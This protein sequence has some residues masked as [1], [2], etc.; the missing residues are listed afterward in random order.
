MRLLS[1]AATA[2]AACACACAALAQDAT[3]MLDAGN[4]EYGETYRATTLLGS[5]VYAVEDEYAPGTVLAA[6]SAGGWTDIGEIGDF[7][8]G[9]DGTL[10]GVVV[11]VGGFLGLG[12]REIA[13]R[14]DAIRPVHE[15]GAE[16]R[17]LLT[18]PATP[19]MIEAAPPLERDP[20]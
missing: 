20:A 7:L 3:G 8:V 12:E 1:T 14:W 16:D 4:L 5:R 18:I 19:K 17:W 13:I 2:A 15:E 9:V 6:G 10:Q 11:D